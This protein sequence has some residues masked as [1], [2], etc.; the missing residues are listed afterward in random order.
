MAAHGNLTLI[1]LK[2]SWLRGGRALT[3]SSSPQS[4]RHSEQFSDNS[5]LD[6]FAPPGSTP[7]QWLE[8]SPVC[9][10][11]HRN[12]A[13][14]LRFQ[15]LF[16]TATE[17]WQGQLKIDMVILVKLQD[18]RECIHNIQFSSLALLYAQVK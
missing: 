1:S 6:G 12:N 2:P 13:I 14:V 5:D 17:C 18:C 15:N 10:H 9:K 7:D 3:A 4:Y 8:A 11:I 16:S